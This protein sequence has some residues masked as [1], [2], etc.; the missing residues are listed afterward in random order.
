MKTLNEALHT[1]KKRF[2]QTT[3]AKHLEDLIWDYL[4]PLPSC[5]IRASDTQTNEFGHFGAD[6]QSDSTWTCD[7]LN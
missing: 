5:D 7:T 4:F 3:S 6:I 1:H 2:Y